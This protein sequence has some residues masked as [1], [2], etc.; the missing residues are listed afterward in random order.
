MP[1]LVR[2]GGAELGVGAGDGELVLAARLRPARRDAAG[3]GENDAR[4][5]T[6]DSGGFLRGGKGGIG[7]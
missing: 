1:G 2:W 3:E 4:S 6:R 7:R 5:F